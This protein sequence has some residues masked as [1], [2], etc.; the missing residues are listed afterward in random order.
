MTTKVGEDKMTTK[1][2]WVSKVQSRNFVSDFIA[3]LKNIIG[4]RLKTYERMLDLAVKEATEELTT[5]YPDV[6][7]VTMQITEFHNASI[8][9]TV[10]GVIN[11]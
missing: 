11:G 10:Y 5:K 2:V 1:I 3:G 6:T 9:V 8:A 7:G 4:G